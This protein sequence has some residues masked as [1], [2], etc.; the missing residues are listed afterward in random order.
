MMCLFQMLTMT[1]NPMLTPVQVFL[2]EAEVGRY[3]QLAAKLVARDE[4]YCRLMR[5][6]WQG[7][8]LSALEL[9]RIPAY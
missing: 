8:V 2:Q 4:P 6:E 7:H 3:P 9:R 5:Q 1:V